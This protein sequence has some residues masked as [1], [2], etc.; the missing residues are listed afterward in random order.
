VA[1]KAVS[2]FLVMP[3]SALSEEVK[4]AIILFF[5]LLDEQQRRLF[6]GLEA[7]Q[8]D[9]NDRWIAE[10]LGVHVQTVAK[11]RKAIVGGD[12][13]VNRSRQPGGGRR[14]TEKKRPRSS[15]TSKR[16]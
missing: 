9:V 6:A 14:P 16:S 12:V 15:R 11:G 13:L 3:G 1:D 5:G 7:L 8:F 4:A 10:L 2:T